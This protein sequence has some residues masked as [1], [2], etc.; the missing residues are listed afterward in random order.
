MARAAHSGPG[1]AGAYHRRLADVHRAWIAP[2]QRVLEVGCGAG[3]LLAACAPSFGVGVDFSSAMVERARARHP[4]LHF[5]VADAHA[6]PLR[7]AFD[8]VILSDL[9]NDLWNV[10]DALEQVAHVCAPHTRVLVSSH[11]KLWEPLLAAALRLGLARPVLHQNWLAA[12]DLRGLLNLAGFEVVRES[13]ENLL[14][15]DVPLLAPVLNRGLVRVTPFN[16]LALTT[17]VAARRKPHPA[18]STPEPVVSVVVPARNE[19]GNIEP[20]F[21]RLPRMGRETEIVFVEGHSRDDTWD[22]I[23]RAMAAHPEW[24]C[25]AHQQT[26]TGKGDAV[27]LGFAKARGE[28]FIILDADLT[29]APEDLPRF[30]AA[31]RRGLGDLINGVRLVYPME[32]QAMRLLN[33]LANHWF[34][35]AFSWLL[36]QRVKDTLCGT[37]VLWRHDYERIAANRAYFGDF[38]PFGDFDLLFGASRLGLRIQDLPIRY[39]QRT[40][41]DTNIRRW[42]H[43]LVLLRMT[44]F[45]LWRLKFR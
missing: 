12:S 2:G 6:L 19:A 39:A 13:R 5:A 15:L 20:L 45:A 21:A 40:Y 30:Y 22:A 32:G 26:R 41:G 1:W 34:S 36:G 11:N 42:R 10:Q 17:L 9:V 4:A 23:R 24:S 37:K 38:D 35:W 28:L 16:H 44:W 8:V 3:D 29:V 25:Q 18:P 31:A 27:R 14:P 43:G 33:L 7:G